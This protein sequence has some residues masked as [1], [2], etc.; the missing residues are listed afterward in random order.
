MCF[1]EIV[2]CA[3]KN[4]P[5]KRFAIAML[6]TECSLPKRSNTIGRL[7]IRTMK[8]PA[9]AIKMTSEEKMIA[10]P[11]SLLESGFVPS[12][13]SSPGLFYRELGELL[14]AEFDPK[15]DSARSVWWCGSP[16]CFRPKL[17]KH[18]L[19][20]HW[21]LDRMNSAVLM[22]AVARP[23]ECAAPSLALG[24]DFTELNKCS[25]EFLWNSA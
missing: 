25:A 4:L 10:A 17:G 18:C 7:K 13:K 22:I 3:L 21:V 16:S 9:N 23:A 14:S 8:W 5:L 15:S 1:W 2:I 20:I 24:E 11:L 19:Y 12:S 6:P